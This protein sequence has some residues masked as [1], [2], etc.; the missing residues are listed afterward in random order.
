M[1]PRATPA[2]RQFARQQGVE[3]AGLSGWTVRRR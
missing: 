1:A 3:L 2:V